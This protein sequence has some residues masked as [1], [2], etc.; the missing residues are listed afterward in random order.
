MFD[1]T[2]SESNIP[3]DGEE[4][5]VKVTDIKKSEKKSKSEKSGS[6]DESNQSTTSTASSTSAQTSKIL[7]VTPES[8]TSLTSTPAPKISPKK[9][10]SA[11]IAI[12]NIIG[13]QIFDETSTNPVPE[14]FK[15]LAVPININTFIET[16]DKKYQDIDEKTK[17]QDENFKSANWIDENGDYSLR[18]IKVAVGSQ[19]YKFI[20]ELLNLDNDGDF[21]FFMECNNYP[22]DE[23]DSPI[24]YLFFVKSGETNYKWEIARK[25]NEKYNYIDVNG[26]VEIYDKPDPKEMFDAIREKHPYIQIYSFKKTMSDNFNFFDK[27]LEELNEPP[28]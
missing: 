1:G 10:Q 16:V 21:H 3:D 6:S 4:S 17:T 23:I 7:S 24:I 28:L 14:N 26:Q 8:N 15:D 19:K 2:K 18:T 27:F 5:E 13:G 11:L 20:A 12:N 9:P 25:I 22:D